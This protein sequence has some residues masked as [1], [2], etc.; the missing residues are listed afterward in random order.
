[1]AD[2]VDPTADQ[3]TALARQILGVVAA[4]VDVPPHLR[5]IA[6]HAAEAILVRTLQGGEAQELVGKVTRV[7]GLVHQLVTELKD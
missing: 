5:P 3:Q 1:M 4:V 2:I 7:A 6:A